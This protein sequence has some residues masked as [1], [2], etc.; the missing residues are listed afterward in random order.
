MGTRKVWTKVPNTQRYVKRGD[1]D[2]AVRDFRA[3]KEGNEIK[4][5]TYKRVK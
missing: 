4:E 3:I 2:S 1:V 5:F